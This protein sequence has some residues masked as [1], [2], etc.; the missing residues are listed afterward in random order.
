MTDK[1]TE[2]RGSKDKQTGIGGVTLGPS[3]FVPEDDG[4]AADFVVM[5][6]GREGRGVGRGRDQSE[7]ERRREGSNKTV[8]HG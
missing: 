5:V 4:L 1:K 3:P 2:K 7:T 8:D 6:G